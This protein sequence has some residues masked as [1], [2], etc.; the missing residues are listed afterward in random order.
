VTRSSPSNGAGGLDFSRLWRSPVR[1]PWLTSVLGLVLLIGIPIEFVTGL[2]SYAAYDP[3]LRYNDPNPDH[4][5]FG[6]YLFNWLTAP[7]WVYRVIEGVHVMLGLMLV[8]VVLA[9]LW[10]VIPK[11][12]VWPPWVSV[13]QLLE[14]IALILVVGGVVF[15][16][17]T[18]ILDI[19]YYGRI[20]FYTSH[21]YGAWAFMA[22]FVVHV[23]VKFGD[24]VHALRSRRFRTELRTGVADTKPEQVDSP[25]VAAAPAAPTISRRGVL[26]LVAGTS[27][28]VF[29]LTAGETIGGHL[30]RFAV[31]GT[32]YRSPG[33][34]ANHFPVNHTA[35]SVGISAAQTGPDWRLEVVG[36]RRVSLSRAE[37]L[38][39]PLTTAELPIACTEG[40]STTQRWTGVPLVDLAHLAGV[41]NP[42][43]AL[44]ETIDGGGVVALSP[45]QTADP[46]SLIALQVNG[47]DLSL[48]HGFP[49]RAIVP[50][51]PGT[52]NRKWLSR[53]V[54]SEA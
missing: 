52:H 8:P 48:D 39:M 43:S 23:A 45:S 22:G 30:R 5:L 10:S 27:L 24:M 17:S 18:G 54:I 15:Q 6:R 41:A 37:L 13:S 16:M 46:S 9:K 36:V 51:A 25:L 26:A 12:F 38:S 35:A 4:G 29:V 21:F 44:L 19:D 2:M 11:L 34:G 49:A 14:R 32:H 47:A 40:W 28:S 31:F 20:P 50:A 3:R 1:G 53:V 33:V 42:G 7:S